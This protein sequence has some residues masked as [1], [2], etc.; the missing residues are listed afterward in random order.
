MKA[1][2]ALRAALFASALG[3]FA[4][5][6]PAQTIDEIRA[7]IRQACAPEFAAYARS[8]KDN[9][10]EGVIHNL[11][12][13]ATAESL[14]LARQNALHYTGQ[15]T[16]ERA[17]GFLS[18]C[19]F[20]FRL[21]QLQNGMGSV[22]KAREQWER[23]L[24]IVA[25]VQA[26]R[27]GGAAP[28]SSAAPAQQGTASASPPVASAG[29]SASSSSTASSSGRTRRVHNPAADAK[30]C[31]QLSG[32]GKIKG[33]VGSGWQLTN[34]CGVPIEGFW[35]IVNTAGQCRNAGTWTIRP[36]GT[37]PIQEEGDI[38]WGACKGRN[39]G[40]MDEGSN[41]EKYTC[42]LLSWN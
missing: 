22:A 20:H 31:T 14:S 39:G 2:R 3:F 34:N 42:H 36:G 25:K 23:F 21:N 38:R 9:Y 35:C 8:P 1:T 6:A 40:G 19:I 17:S 29:S 4:P 11:A 26:D 30:G 27:T 18:G 37:W 10:T 7:E 15:G 12:V 13:G 33:V 24:V 32:T 16:I 5:P 41:G 28:S